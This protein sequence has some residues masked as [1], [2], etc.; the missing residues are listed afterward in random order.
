[1]ILKLL[2]LSK[3]IREKL[4][5]SNTTITAFKNSFQDYLN[6]YNDNATSYNGF[7]GFVSIEHNWVF[8]YDDKKNIDF[9][10]GFC[11]KTDYKHGYVIIDH[12]DIE[13]ELYNG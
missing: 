4:K 1:M 3:E 11:Y 12:I 9:S 10:V 8:W 7:E 5:A 6:E 13:E 2:R